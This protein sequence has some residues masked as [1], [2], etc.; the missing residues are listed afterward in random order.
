MGGTRQKTEQH[1]ARRNK[2]KSHVLIS[3]RTR[4][5]NQWNS[6][7]LFTWNQTRSMRLH[8]NLSHV[9]HT[10][11]TKDSR[12]LTTTWF[13]DCPLKL[14]GLNDR[15]DKRNNW[16][17][18]NV[19]LHYR[20]YIKSIKFAMLSVQ[21]KVWRLFICYEVFQVFAA[22]HGIIFC[23]WCQYLAYVGSLPHMR[24]RRGHLGR[25]C[26]NVL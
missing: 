5:R 21:W 26:E 17:I 19:Y 4:T 10:M 23:N 13:Y 6:L 8:V 16:C 25:W 3:N 11:A 9:L 1:M 20:I 12:A 2:N 22:P 18:C 7:T 24:A 14:V 15:R